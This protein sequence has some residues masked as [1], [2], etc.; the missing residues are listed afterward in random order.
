[1]GKTKVWI[2]GA[3]GRLGNTITK[4]LNYT[5]YIIY[6]SKF[7]EGD[8][9]VFCVDTCILKGYLDLNRRIL[10]ERFS[11]QDYGVGASKDKPELIDVA[12][13]VL[14]ELNYLKISLF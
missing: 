12:N 13:K 6:T 1:M 14:S 7:A 11:P 4:M 8:I 3:K 5:E 2:T 10:P 9:D